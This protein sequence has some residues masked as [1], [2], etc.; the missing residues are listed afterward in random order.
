MSSL[1]LC[2][3]EIVEYVYSALDGARYIGKEVQDAKYHHNTS[4]D[5]AVSICKYGIL[6][7]DDLNK[8]GIRNDSKRK[9]E[10]M[11]DIESHA[12]G[13]DSVSLSVVG[14][15]DLYPNEDEYNPFSPYLVDFLVTSNIKAS[16]TSIRYGNEFLC[17]RSINKKELRSV[18]IR[19]LKLIELGKKRSDFEFIS[20]IIKNYNYL[21]GIAS[22]LNTQ[23]LDIPLREMSES[24]I[25]ELDAEK[26]LSQPKLVLKR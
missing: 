2:E 3:N 22:E 1:E 15:D 24:S 26:L 13:I 10:I 11:G 7:L 21:L 5:T 20:N 17:R 9:L 19:L 14:L 18:D 4:Y 12:N 16:R 23:G 25:F 8:L 6:T